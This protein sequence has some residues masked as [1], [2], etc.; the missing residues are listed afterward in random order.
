ATG[1]VVRGYLGVAIQDLTPDL[2]KSFGLKQAKG[3]L[4]SSVA[5]DSPAERAGI[6]QGDVITAY[7]GKPVEDPATLQREVT[8][9]PVGTKAAMKVIRNGHEQEITVTIGEQS[10]RARVASAEL[11]M[12]NALAR[13]EVQSLD[14]QMARELGLSGKTHGVVVVGVEPESLADRAGVTQGDVIREINRQPV[15]SVKDYEKVAS[16]LKKDEPALLLI[17]RRGASLFVTVKA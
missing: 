1:K 15:R 17:N 7:Q 16:S 10:D 12:E 4:V 8:R 3:A 11:S 2:S 6:K 13:L 9:T 14:R 5:E